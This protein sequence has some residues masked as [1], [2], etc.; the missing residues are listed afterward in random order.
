MLNN[1]VLY[2]DPT[3]HIGGVGPHGE[4]LTPAQLS[5]G[6]ESLVSGVVD[7]LLVEPAGFVVNV[8]SSLANQ[9]LDDVSMAAAV[10]GVD[11]STVP[12]IAMVDW[13]IGPVEGHETEYNVGYWGATGAAAA[14]GIVQGLAKGGGWLA[15]KLGGKAAAGAADDALPAALQGGEAKVKVYLGISNGKP[16]YVGISSN[17]KQR[18]AQHGSRFELLEEVTSSPLTQ[19][20]ARAIEEALFVRHPN[21][22]N[23]RHSIS[24]SHSWYQD[25]L[26]WGETWLR[27]NWH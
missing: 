22:Q 12:R 13:G 2:S 8:F 9:T 23:I 27:N 21:F 10:F 14:K 16:N 4:P 7:A 18:A 24:P 11:M 3:G 25:A 26:D 17:L 15:S 6:E 20:Q 1:P 5:P 19:G